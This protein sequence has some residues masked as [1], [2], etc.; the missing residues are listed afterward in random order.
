MQRKTVTLAIIKRCAKTIARIDGISQ[1][2][3]ARNL[4]LAYGHENIDFSEGAKTA[5]DDDLNFV[6]GKTRPMRPRL[7]QPLPLT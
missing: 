5:P 7:E 3:A 2:Q 1:D 4:I 6:N